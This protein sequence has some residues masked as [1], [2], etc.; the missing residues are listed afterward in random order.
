PH[1][2]DAVLERLWL[3]VLLHLVGRPLD[4]LDDVLVSGAPANV[5]LEGVPDFLLA[6]VRVALQQRDTGHDHAGRAIP[7]LQ[8][9]HL[10]EALLDRVQVGG[11][12][13]ALDPGDLGA[14]S[15]DGQHGARLHARTIHMD[16]AGAA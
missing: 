4:G 3:G 8:A 5:P 15:L 14:I 12:A 6:W 2:R 7:T 10:P 9:V 1:L 13:E 16:G 11:A